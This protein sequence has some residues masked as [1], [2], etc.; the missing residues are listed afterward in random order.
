M[1]KFD[2]KSR[3]HYI[4]K[5][6]QVPL[7]VLRVFLEGGWRTKVLYFT[8]FPF[9]LP[10]ACYTFTKVVR[11]LVRYWR[12]QGLRAVV[13]LDDRI[14]AAEGKEVALR[15]SKGVKKNFSKAGFVENPTGT[16]QEYNMT[17]L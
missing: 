16:Q 2:L 10:T 3:Y 17:G 8:V 5:H 7:E 1:F 12:Y 4:R 9:G 13:Y 14:V 6:L 11:L 15:A